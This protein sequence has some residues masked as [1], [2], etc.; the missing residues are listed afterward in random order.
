MR[1]ASRA[2]ASVASFS[3]SQ[4][5]GGL[6]DGSGLSA[7]VE[8]EPLRAGGAEEDQELGVLLAEVLER[9]AGAAWDVDEVTRAGVDLAAA[10]DE[11]ERSGRD[12][13]G[14]VLTA[15]RVR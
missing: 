3:S 1:W 13:K 14:L 7:V 4:G 6:P 11:A 5:L 2:P 8:E 12:V 10:V 9:V 15:V